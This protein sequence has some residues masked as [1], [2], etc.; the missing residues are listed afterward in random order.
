MRFRVT[1]EEI[2][3]FSNS[4]PVAIDGGSSDLD[5]ILRFT[6]MTS[7]GSDNTAR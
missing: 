3:G 2:S 1:S 5:S 7:F 4:G 6:G